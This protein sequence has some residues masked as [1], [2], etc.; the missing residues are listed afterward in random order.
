MRTESLK[1]ILLCT[2]CL[3]F[4]M[5]FGNC[6][7]SPSKTHQIVGKSLVS[8]S[9]YN[10][11]DVGSALVTSWIID[12]SPSIRL[13]INASIGSLPGI[14]VSFGLFVG[15]VFTGLW[16]GVEFL[17][18]YFSFFDFKGVD[19]NVVSCWCS[20]KCLLEFWGTK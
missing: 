2:Q 20:L 7:E 15:E 17:F 14:S 4:W 13:S 11:N 18:L 1:L 10:S 9:L 3:K 16:K 19:L 8:N 12:S 5:K 6:L